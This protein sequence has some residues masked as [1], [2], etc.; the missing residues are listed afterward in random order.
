MVFFINGRS[1]SFF[2][3]YP[4]PAPQRGVFYFQEF[5][6]LGFTAPPRSTQSAGSFV[7]APLR[8]GVT[9]NRIFTGSE[10]R[11]LPACF[12][13]W[14]YVVAADASEMRLS[15]NGWK[16]ETGGE[17]D[18]GNDFTIADQSIEIGGVTVPVTYSGG[19]SLVVTNGGL[20][21]QSD[22]ISPASFGLSKFDYGTVLWIKTRISLASSAHHIPYSSENVGS[23]NS[24]GA[25]GSQVSWYDPANTTVS[26]TDTAGVYTTTGTSPSTRVS[27]YRSI[28]WSRFVN[29]GK[30]FVTVGDSIAQNI[31]DG[32]TPYSVHGGGYV[33]RSMHSATGTDLLPN[34]NLARS[35]SGSGAIV[36]SNTKIRQLYKY[37]R[38]G[39][40]EYGTNN[41]DTTTLRTDLQAIWSHM[42]AAGIEKIVR[43]KYLPR[44][45]STDSWATESNQT[46]RSGGKWQTG[47][48]ADLNNQWFDT[49]VPSTLDVVVATTTAQ[50]AAD[51]GDAWK[52]R[53]NGTA[54]YVNS[55]DTHPDSDGHEFIATTLRPVLRSL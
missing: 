44:T 27:G 28:I 13:R 49:L 14:Q 40:D 16:L 33:Q 41:M 20:D 43:M 54:N 37:A 29:D 15:N 45:T 32:G 24:G 2:V 53:V 9:N 31:N 39:I 3:S 50:A 11:T 55:D 30:S 23:T 52:W 46:Y 7:P 6:M 48:D 18:V 42:R 17:Q 4:N 8:T 5:V 10:S 38:L 25:S 22:A 26:S 51:G 47:G 36:G 21:I 1:A 12:T 19:R 34:L 35:G